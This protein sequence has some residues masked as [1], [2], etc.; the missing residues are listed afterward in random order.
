MPLGCSVGPNFTRPDP[1]VP[2]QWSPASTSSS[3]NT[4]PQAVVTW[5]TNFQ[6]PT[7]VSLIE[8]S[9]AS[10]LDLRA[11]VLRITEARAE[12]DVASAA[13]WPRVD[14]NA[15]YTRQRLSD[16]TTTG[17]VFADFGNV[18]IPGVPS[19]SVPN[20]SNQFQLGGSASWEIDLFG[21][22][23]RSVEAA[24]ADL[25]ASVEDQRA[26]LVSLCADVA[27]NYIELRGAQL[28]RD[29]TEQSLA[30]QGE[31]YDLTRQRQAVGLTTDLDVANAGA[32]LDST[33]ALV[34][35]LERE[36]TQDINQLSLLMGREPDTLRT[37]LEA[38]RPVPQ[39]P[40][41]L[42]IGLPSEL[43]RRR[44]DIRESEA[45]L[46]AATARIG[47]AVG[48]LFPRLTLSANGGVQSQSASDLL[49]WASRFG[50]IGPTLEIPLFDGSRWATVRLQNV[51]AQEAAL[52]YERTVLTALHEVENALA[53]YK[54][55]R[56]RGVSLAAAVEQSRDALNLARERYSSGVANFIDVLDAERSLQQ[57]ELS[58]ATNTTAISTDLV[59]IYRALGGGWESPT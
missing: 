4:D 31:L 55:D 11:A 16:T 41:V 36:V 20:P 34:P 45:R 8:R 53:A 50:T 17:A 6:E 39:V 1:R 13:F 32:Q 10:N 37:E 7:L 57:N 54:A 26:V 19:I 9:T 24:N 46:H 12:R 59:A 15:S 23:R 38:A 56:D 42:P 43:A 2:A 27:R 18:K 58:A 40:P 3:L 30:T 51:R 48:D 44:P 5:W 49:K 33:R 28:R 14:A 52:D 25:Q 47:V 22:V 29:V 21:R 35:Q